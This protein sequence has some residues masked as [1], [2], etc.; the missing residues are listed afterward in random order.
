MKV[1][2]IVFLFS[3]SLVGCSSSQKSTNE[4]E[5]RSQFTPPV[6]SPRYL[7]SVKKQRVETVCVSGRF[8]KGGAWMHQSWVSLIIEDS[9]MVFNDPMIR[10][11]QG[12]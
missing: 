11:I 3:I 10:K 5:K 6:K 9:D 4:L 2:T 7:P 12:K 1:L 8:L